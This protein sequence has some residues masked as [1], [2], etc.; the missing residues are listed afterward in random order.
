MGTAD[1]A[2]LERVLGRFARAEE[3]G[4]HT[5]WAGHLF[6]FDPLVLLALA[7]RR[8]RRIE[9]GSWVVRA[10]PLHPVALA[11]Q[12][13]AV[14]SACDNRLALG[15][16]AGHPGTVEQRLGLDY[17]GP[18]RQL[19]EVIAALR[20]LLA[21]EATSHSGPR[22]RAHAKLAVRDARPPPILLAALGPAMLRLAGGA[23]DGVAIWLG[24]PRYLE[25]FALPR[26]REAARRAGRGTPRVA[27]AVPVALCRDVARGR[28]AAEA[29]L[30]PSARL[31]AYARVLEREGATSPADVAITGDERALRRGLA[32]LTDLGVDDL[33]AVCFPLAGDPEAARR[34]E[35]LLAEISRAS[36]ARARPS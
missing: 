24:G 7:G 10:H 20:P 8:T 29:F 1:G 35:A 16:G 34:T 33:N 17:G 4:F 18:A 27:C 11:Q 14:Q 30:A 25:S 22:L 21:G 28:A 6:G 23:A 32:R 9:L 36:R 12:A 13:L 26:L 31:A 2:P 19:R 15:I 5:A 3:A